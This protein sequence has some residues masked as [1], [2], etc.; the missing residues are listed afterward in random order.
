MT[1]LTTR[2]RAPAVAAVSP[3]GTVPVGTVPAAPLTTLVQPALPAPAAPPA[4]AAIDGL[5]D[6]ASRKAR[7][8]TPSR[9]RC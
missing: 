8:P 5:I 1:A 9:P 4:N 3:V 6:A 2:W 7:G